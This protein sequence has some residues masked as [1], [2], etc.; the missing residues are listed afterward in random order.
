[1]AVAYP[2]QQQQFLTPSQRFANTGSFGSN[3]VF[4]QG[5]SLLQ[6]SSYASSDSTSQTPPPLSVGLYQAN[7][8]LQRQARP[9]PSEVPKHEVHLPPIP[10]K[11]TGL[12]RQ[13]DQQFQN[14]PSFLSASTNGP[15]SFVPTNTSAP[16]TPKKRFFGLGRS[17]TAADTSGS[18]KEKGDRKNKGQSSKT[19]DEGEGSRRSKLASSTNTIKH[20]RNKSSDNTPQTPRKSGFFQSRKSLADSTAKPPTITKQT[21]D[22]SDAESW[23][24]LSQ[25]DVSKTSFVLVGSD[26][27][28][29]G[30]YLPDQAPNMPMAV[31]TASNR[32]SQQR[33]PNAGRSGPDRSGLPDSTQQLRKRDDDDLPLLAPCARRA[34]RLPSPGTSVVDAHQ[35]GY[36]RTHTSPSSKVFGRSTS[37]R[38]GVDYFAQKALL[39]P[40][41]TPQRDAQHPE[42]GLRALS[43]SHPL[44]ES[45]L[46]SVCFTSR[47]VG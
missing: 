10:Q 17:A 14:Y 20:K 46:P 31:Q 12:F 34:S 1:M 27:S 44:R 16:T 5:G 36:T 8:F 40:P 30:P 23:L 15:N 9:H 47:K 22:D 2:Q 43:A 6:R 13:H 28:G 35:Q 38:T 4:A 45:D 39:T 3:G 19:D 42:Q 33:S 32:N 7:G 24:V 41:T 25:S 29:S 26:I 21:N 18:K 37:D 11:P